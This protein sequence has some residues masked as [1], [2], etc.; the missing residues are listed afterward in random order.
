[1]EITLAEYQ[2]DEWYL[3]QNRVLRVN[4]GMPIE[5]NTTGIMLGCLLYAWDGYNGAYCG[6]IYFG[7]ILLFNAQLSEGDKLCWHQYLAEKWGL[8]ADVDSDLDGRKDKWDFNNFNSSVQ[9]SS[10]LVPDVYVDSTNSAYEAQSG[11]CKIGP[12]PAYTYDCNQVST[13]GQKSN[14]FDTL[15]HAISAVASGGTLWLK[16]GTLYPGS[17]INLIQ[18]KTDIKIRVAGNVRCPREGWTYAHP[19]SGSF[20]SLQNN[21]CNGSLSNTND[22][23]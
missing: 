6:D 18:G 21:N 17:Y 1:M 10:T 22:T 11:G 5:S 19:P 13:A 3:Y 15:S 12:P 16:A 9:D 20:A 4:T 7:E 14:P 23:C 8:K 2:N